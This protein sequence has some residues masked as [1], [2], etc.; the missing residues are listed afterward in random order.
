MLCPF[1]LLGHGG[2]ILTEGWRRVKRRGALSG[3]DN[4]A[5]CRGV[6][7]LLDGWLALPDGANPF[8]NLSSGQ[9]IQDFL[10]W[11]ANDV[12]QLLARHRRIAVGQEYPEDRIY[13]RQVLVDVTGLFAAMDLEHVL[14]AIYSCHLTRVS[15][16]PVDF[17]GVEV[18]A[19]HGLVFFT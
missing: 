8:V 3:N 14:Q 13:E 19:E 7:L 15:I 16:H 2:G 6:R 11:L 9:C 5:T 1:E 12:A 17:L 18:I 4:A 10:R